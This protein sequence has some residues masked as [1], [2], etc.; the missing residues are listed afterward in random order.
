MTKKAIAPSRKYLIITI[1]ILLVAGWSIQFSGAIAAPE[2]QAQD[3]AVITNPPSNAVVQGTIQIT[4]SADHPAFQFYAIEFSPEPVTGNQ[5]QII[6]ATQQTPVIDGVLV[7]W[8]TTTV[9]DGSYTLRLRTVRLDGNYTEFFVQ[10][11]VVA[12]TQLI[13]TDTPTPSSLET[14]TPLG[15]E[16]VTPTVTPTDLPPT[17]TIVIDQPIVDTPTPRPVET[18][19]PLEDPAENQSFVPTITGF[20]LIPLRDACL[21]GGLIMIG[22]FVLFGFFSALR[23]FIMGF[24]NRRRL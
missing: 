22:V 11:V 10:Q 20:S 23:M 18:S 19:A 12:N 6:Q 7:T 15:P 4:G 1:L 5:W 3:L 2:R 17:P 8:D 13:P 16:F 14:P 24:V 9:P 21:Y